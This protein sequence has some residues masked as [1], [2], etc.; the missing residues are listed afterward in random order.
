MCILTVFL[1][2]CPG[3]ALDSLWRLNPEAHRAFQSIGKPAILLMCMVGTACGF[4]AVG[5]WRGSRWAERLAILIL[6]F[7]IAGDVFNAVVRHDYRALIGLPI[8]GAMILYLI[9]S[10]RAVRDE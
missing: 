7:N 9:R 1:V 10:A 5:L 6:A 4:A 3:S 8:G 2:C